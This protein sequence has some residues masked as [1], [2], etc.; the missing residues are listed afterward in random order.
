M[1]IYDTKIGKSIFLIIIATI[2]VISGITIYKSQAEEPPHPNRPPIADAGPDQT[3]YKGETVTLNGT[4]SYD[5]DGEITW[6]KWDFNNDG[7][8]DAQGNASVASIVTTTYTSAGIYTVVLSVEDNYIPP[9]SDTDTCI[10]TVYTQ[11]PIADADGPYYINEGDGVS[12]DGSGSY[13]PD[14]SIASWQWDLDDDGQY[15]DANGETPYISWSSLK[16]LGIDDDG[17]YTIGLKVTDNDGA[18]NTTTTSITV[19]NTP[20][21]I[22]G[23]P[24]KVGDE[25]SPITFVAGTVYDPGDDT[26]EYRWDWNNDGVYDTTWSSSPTKQ[27][28]WDDDYSGIVRVQVRD[29]DGGTDYDTC[30]VTVNNVAPST[31]T[32]IV[33]TPSHVEVGDTLTA[34]ASGSTDVPA[35]VVTYYYK[36]YDVDLSSVIQDWSTDNN[37]VVQLAQKNHVIRVYT[38][39]QDDDGGVSGVYSETMMVSNIPP[40]ALFNYAPTIPSP[41]EMTIFNASSSYDPDGIIANWTW[42]FGD[43]SHGYGEVVYHAFS[44][45]NTYNVHLTVKDDNGGTDDV[46]L[47]V[48]VSETPF[49]YFTY[50][51]NKNEVTFNA[52]LSFDYDGVITNYSWNFGDGSNGYGNKTVHTYIQT[53]L[54]SVTLTVTD[55]SGKSNSTSHDVLIDLTPPKT[56]LFATPSNPNGKNGWYVSSISIKLVAKDDLS[57]INKIMYKLDTN[58]WKEYNSEVVVKK[59]GSHA[60]YY[61]SIDNEGN[62]E[63]SHTFLFKIDFTPP[64]TNCSVEGTGQNN[65]FRGSVTV[66]LNTADNRSSV[67]KLLYRINGG[68]YITYSA[69]FDINGEGKY[70]IEYFSID[71]AGNPEKLRNLEIN[72]DKTS[73]SLTIKKPGNYLYI[74][75]REIIP[76][77]TPIIIKGIEI[78][79]DASDTLSG[80]KEVKFYID[81]DYKGKDS[82]PPYTWEWNEFAFGFHEIKV[83]AVDEAGNERVKKVTAFVLNFQ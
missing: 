58:P 21:T 79:A 17:T 31:P 22:S 69:P 6:Y 33:F 72:I 78:E 54:Y 68:D 66:F 29:D 62:A 43:G 11:S 46:V 26:F 10:I 7:I 74:A 65:W 36:F 60:F 55:D 75:G 70:L 37:I 47:S 50:S 77:P 28:T 19:S 49:A 2:I 35:D 38:R 71:R 42:D 48:V 30:M 53:G 1:G 5:P 34:I 23:T 51:I 73:P 27:H 8:W 80:I 52:S 12:L 39:A 81:G 67:D 9:D 64:W 63:D 40:V 24:D 14:G 45:S 25:G 4:G 20:P 16:A 57:D 18:S 82:T 61:Y 3:V 56:K 83:V 32:D 44:S 76:T 41:G 15:D 13:D 59:E